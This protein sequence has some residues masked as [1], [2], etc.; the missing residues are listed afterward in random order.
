MSGIK[1]RHIPLSF[2]TLGQREAEY[3][4]DCLES[5]WISSAGKYVERF[6]EAFA[7]VA[8][9]K[10]AISC[11]NGTAALHLALLGLGLQP[12]DE[13]I[14]PT[15]TF[16]ACANAVVYCGGTP[17]FVDIDPE[18]WCL[19]ATQLER[20]ITAKTRGIIAVHLRG[21]PADMNAVMDVARRH[22]LFVVED[23][24]Q[25]HGARAQG[26]PVGSIGEAGTFSFFGNKMLTTGEGGMVTTNAD[27]V[28]ARIRL[29]K[30]QGMTQ[31]RRYWHPVV[32]YNYRLTNVQAAIGLAQV[33]RLDDQL[34]CHREVVSWYQ[35][36]LSGVHGLSW[37]QQRDWALHAWWQFVAVI[38]E[39]FAKDR[40]SVLERLQHAGIDARRIYFPMHQL[41]IFQDLVRSDRFPVADH[42]AERAICLP[43]YAGLQRDDVRFVCRTL[44]E[45]AVPRRVGVRG[46]L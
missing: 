9:T 12:G 6:E 13:V 21:H 40:D 22:G 31:E 34:R 5:K 18:I 14:V 42:L 10:H 36:E 29:L 8:G 3:V 28:A 1:Q 26:Q 17:V 37:Q 2:P 35:E 39:S 46:V 43:T 19:D 4:M 20:H 16:V 45:S 38:D 41:P 15:L 30:N 24:A 11:S 7:G 32:G 25:A 23:A 44:L 33:E 27:D